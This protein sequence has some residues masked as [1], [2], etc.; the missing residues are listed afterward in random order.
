M[1]RVDWTHLPHGVE[2]LTLEGALHD[3]TLC[4]IRSDRMACSVELVIDVAHLREHFGLDESMRVVLRIDGVASVRAEQYEVWPGP[5]PEL[6]GL[7]HAEQQQLVDAYRTKWRAVSVDWTEFEQRVSQE[8]LWILDAEL[9]LSDDSLTFT[10]NGEVSDNDWYKFFVSG[11]T[12]E[13]AR[14]DGVPCSFDELRAMGTAYWD[15]FAACAPQR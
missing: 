5:R 8:S 2:P 13:I 7:S 10:A 1:E 15:A 9:A 11:R 14:T 4:A 12:L 6:V 3:G